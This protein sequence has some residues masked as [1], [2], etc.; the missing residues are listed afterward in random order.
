MADRDHYADIL[1]YC[2]EGGPPPPQWD[3]SH[4]FHV[5][6]IGFYPRVAAALRELREL[7]FEMDGLKK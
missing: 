5:G 7:R 6:P 2:E 3:G 4:R 1:K